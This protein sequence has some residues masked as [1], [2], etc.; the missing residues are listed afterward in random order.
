MGA[1]REPQPPGGPR[2]S[3]FEGGVNRSKRAIFLTQ[4]LQPA[5][6]S[7]AWPPVGDAEGCRVLGGGVA[8]RRSRSLLTAARCSARPGVLLRT[9]GGTACGA[10]SSETRLSQRLRQPPLL[11][12]M[13]LLLT[14]M[15]RL[16][17]LNSHL[18]PASVPA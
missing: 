10:G 16:P 18:R 11:L 6:L 14:S 5:L 15:P 12:Q 3:V 4:I 1:E 7:V 17:G 13:L 9:C 8:L 2:L